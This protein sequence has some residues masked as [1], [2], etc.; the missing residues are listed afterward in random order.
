MGRG[1]DRELPGFRW[2]LRLILGQAGG[3]A[4]FSFLFMAFAKLQHLLAG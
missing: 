3:E 1:A 4:S 2:G